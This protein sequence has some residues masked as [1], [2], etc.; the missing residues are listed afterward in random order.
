MKSHFDLEQHA[1][2]ALPDDDVKEDTQ[3][4]PSKTSKKRPIWDQ[5]KYQVAALAI[6]AILGLTWKLSGSAPSTPSQPQFTTY[7]PISAPEQEAPPDIAL[8]T[9][10]A[11]SLPDIVPPSPP[12][13]D[14]R[15]ITETSSPPESLATEVSRAINAQQVYGE[16]TRE[17]LSALA[18]R[19]D[20]VEQRL[21]ESPQLRNTPTTPSVQVPVTQ[22]IEPK[23]TATSARSKPRAKSSWS[24]HKAQINSLYPG[25]AWV[26]WQGSSWAL[27]PGDRFAGATVLSIDESK[28][29]IVTSSGV[30]R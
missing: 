26:T 8:A 19:L 30:I 28:R 22:T 4:I 14:N 18:R 7:A 2:E 25:L 9:P 13:L 5:P 11:S 23:T 17:G 27:R 15:E 16:K 21:S 24:G 6:F 3:Q 29:E 12:T 20:A 1:P 10:S